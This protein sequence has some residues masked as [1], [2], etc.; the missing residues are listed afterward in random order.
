M[1][2]M[3]PVLAFGFIAPWLMAAG[4][5]AT[6][7][8]IVIHLLNKRKFRVV[9]WAA[10]DF[11]LAAQRRNARRLRFQRWLL[12]AVR[13]LALLVIAAGIAQLTL[14]SAV[15]GNVLGGQRAVVVVWDDSYS[16]AWQKGGGAGKQSAFERSRKLLGDWLGQVPAGDKVMVIR[17]S[18]LG[19]VAGNKPTL[20]HK[21]LRA[22]VEA[23][24][25]S[26]AGT[27]LVAAL[28]QAT[29]TLK[30][31]EKTTNSRQ[32]VILTDLSR[33]SL[34]SGQWSVAR[35]QKGEAGEE[36]LKKSMGALKKVA[37]GVKVVDLGD[38][39]QANMAVVEVR[40][41]RPMVV[42][43]SAAE[44]KITVLNATDRPQIDVP[45]TVSLDG[46]IVHSEKLGKIDP[47]STRSVL[48]AVTIATAGRH[49]VE[50]KLPP[51]LLGMDDVRRLMVNVQREIPLLVVDGSPGDNRTLGSATYVAVAYALAADNKSASVFAPKLITELELGTTALPGFAAV[52][53]SDTAAPGTAV[54]DGLRKYVEEGGLLIL[55]PGSRTDAA[56]TNE[57][58]GEGGAKLLPAA[59][60]Q[61]VK[62]EGAREAAEGI[63]FDP[64]GFTH[65][66]LQMFGEAARGGK[67][68]GFV[69]VQTSQYLKLAVPKDGTVETILK[70]AAGDKRAADAA[71][72][73]R[74]V[75]KGRVVQFASSADT[76][77]NGFAAKPSFVPFLHELT[78][79]ALPRAAGG[80][81]LTLAIGEKI[82]L[83]A[84]A[85]SPGSWV[86]P[87]NERMS[88][89]TV[90][91]KDGRARLVSGPLLR[92]GV[93]AATTGST[94]AVVAVNVDAE[95]ADIRHVSAGAFATAAG[96]DAADVVLGNSELGIVNSERGA[97][98][99]SGSAIGRWLILAALGFFLVETLLAR[100]F[101]VYR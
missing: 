32:V 55:F 42:A 4:A 10:M 61:P 52:I 73:T 36:R 44:F 41:Q 74:A 69:S 48:A 50:A 97:T 12:L 17:A 101:S 95:E 89:T 33:S 71:V 25:V 28:D 59:Y 54:R 20:D 7:I 81:A 8:P 58:L 96:I 86:M 23:T 94:A 40:A 13:C 29:E 57:V 27:D 77:W 3:M 90:V 64:E 49:L 35:G 24:A 21:G 19:P 18:R 79:Y 67:D 87:G 91:E 51:D 31:I 93:Y 75:G 46:V 70:Y 65:P 5:A 37:T 56:R 26:D 72:V 22:Q 84:D 15:I 88:V 11:L 99:E 2:L 45:V 38:A 6:S 39:G 100:L 47:G 83:A 43:G 80:E 34:G 30:D 63:R 62:L 14:T 98:G 66:V 68:V 60:G 53:L 1:M 82:N 92:A 9:V 16:M 85:A 78:Y 76:T